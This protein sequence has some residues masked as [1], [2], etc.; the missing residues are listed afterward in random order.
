MR[1]YITVDT[2]TS[3]GG[4]WRNPD[5]AP[6][7]LDL[8]VF[9]R[10]G[11]RCYGIPLIMDILEQYG[12]RATFFVE[13]F[14]AYLLG[15]EAVA[16][17]FQ[18][19]RERG[20]DAQLHLHPVQRFYRDFLAGQPRR[21]RDLMFELPGQE[22]ADLVGEGVRLFRE[23]SGATPVAY[24]AG[25]YGASEIT[26]R[27]LRENGIRIDSS[28]NAAYLGASC[29]FRTGPL[30]APIVIEDVHEFPVTV[31][32]SPWAAGYKPLEIS[33]VSVGEVLTTLRSLRSSGCQDAVLVLHSFSLLKT[34]GVR[35]EGH[36]PDRIVIHRLRRLCAALSRMKGEIEVAVLGESDFSATS[37]QQ[38]QIIPSVG[39]LRPPI[40]K[41]VQA[42]NRIPWI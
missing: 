15:H 3:L 2:E 29:G 35:F 31:F 41:F 23:L 36:R 1:V 33:A 28:Y 42:V 27:A 39:W 5:W 19:I 22:Q 26:L 38:P 18:T 10:Y 37:F 20:H 9:G 12:F 25:C 14:C 11:S 30:N 24:R 21:E 4:A 32:R 40:R 17:V 7:A 6:L 16:S 8:T 34:R 13:V